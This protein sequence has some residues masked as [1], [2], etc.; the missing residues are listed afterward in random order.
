MSRQLCAKIADG[1]A[2][3]ANC[4]PPAS[5]GL[6][7]RYKA[8]SYTMCGF[9]EFGT[10]TVP[11]RKYRKL[12]P[13]GTA[14]YARNG[15][16]CPGGNDAPFEQTLSGHQVYNAS[17]CVLTDTYS[18]VSGSGFCADLGSACWTATSKTRK[19]L[20][21]GCCGSIFGSPFGWGI[22]SSTME[23]LLT[24]ED[25]EQ[26]AV[27]R[28]LPPTWTTCTSGCTGFREIRG[29][30]DFSS[31]FQELQVRINAGGGEVGVN[32]RATVNVRRRLHASGSPYVD[33]L[34]LYHQFTQIEGG[35]Q[36]D[37]II[38]PNFPGYEVMIS[39]CSVVIDA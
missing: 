22:Y 9:N 36:S 26:D 7:Y 24:E 5:C 3:P 18:C 16:S 10:P 38:V 27:D 6:E 1:G 23:Q 19:E 32:Y 29:A 34:E 8:G 39:G 12:T 30:G 13:Q 4:C 21:V 37:W 14:S 33:F 11:P 17:T 15:G 28:A 31:T 25:T 2:A 35:Y 20:P